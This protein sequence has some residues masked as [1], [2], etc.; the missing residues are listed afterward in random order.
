M[1]GE[2][3]PS[4]FVNFFVRLEEGQPH[5]PVEHP[6]WLRWGLGRHEELV[7]TGRFVPIEPR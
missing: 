3:L 2:A 6:G 4:S 7:D 1:S 5:S